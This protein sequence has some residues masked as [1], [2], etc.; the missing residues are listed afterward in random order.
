[1]LKLS[2]SQSFVI[3]G[4]QEVETVEVTTIMGKA[5]VKETKDWLINLREEGDNM[6]GGPMKY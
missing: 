4:K 1:M 2:C 6:Q 3:F 5:L